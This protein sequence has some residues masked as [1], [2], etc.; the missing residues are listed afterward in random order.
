MAAMKPGTAAILYANELLP[1]N[2]DAHYRFRQNN[3]FYYLTGI[4]QEDCMLFLFPDAPR[5][6]LREVLFVKPTSEYIQIWEGW[7]YSPEEATAASGIAAIRYQGDFESF[8]LQNIGFTEG[9]YLEY[10]EH[11]RNSLHYP[12]PA[13]RLASWLRDRFPAH[14]LHRA[15]PLLYR[16]RMHKEPEEVAQIQHAVDITEKAFRRVLQIMKPG[17]MEYEIEG[18]IVG[19]FLRNGSAGAGYESIIASGASACVLHYIQNDKPCHDGD[20]VLMDFGA[21]YGNYNADLTRC[22]PANGRF[23][24]RQK[25]LYGLV[26]QMKN[27]AHSILRP[28]LNLYQYHEQV[29]AFTT[30]LLLSA[31]MLTAEEVKAA[32]QDKPAYKKY[33]P[34]GTSHHLGLDVHDVNHWF[35]PITPGM[36]FTIEPGLYLREEGIG[37]RLEDDVVI[38]ATGQQNL[39]ANIP[40]QLDEIEALMAR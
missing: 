32:P 1:H 17:V 23:S 30:E 20:L 26:L 18:E 37:I 35:D 3:S 22:I 31:G 13:H 27:H 5:A 25:E 6:D 19:E 28:G 21:M 40:L 38:T 34:H 10:N 14:A 15:A 7:K 4:D 9:L 16:L 12:F 2:G 24:A 11:H 29:G 8:L 36:V 33:F 39:M